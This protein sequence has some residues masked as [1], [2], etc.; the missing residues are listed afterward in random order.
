MW[1]GGGGFDFI[2][3]KVLI[4]PLH[5]QVLP[6]PVGRFWFPL[7]LVNVNYSDLKLFLLVVGWLSWFTE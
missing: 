1:A 2:E 5:R 7:D 3:Q 6:F 4:Q